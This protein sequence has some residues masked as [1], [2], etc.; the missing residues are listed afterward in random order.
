MD[1]EL[2]LSSAAC[3]S[4]GVLSPFRQQTDYIRKQIAE[5]FDA[6][7]LDR[8]QILIGT[9]YTFQGEER[10]IMLISLA[11]DQEVHPSTFQILDREDVFNVSITRARSEQWIITSL[12][13]PTGY[14]AASQLE[15]YIAHIEQADLQHR[16][17]VKPSYHDTFLTSVVAWLREQGYQEIHRQY[18]IAG[19][20]VDIVLVHQEATFCINLIGYPGEMEEAMSVEQFNILQRVGILALPLSYSR[21]YF[22]TEAAERSLRS[23]LN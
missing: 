21:W 17:K 3:Q 13:Q 23:F 8:H 22:D 5:K 7:L 1:A 15:R 18:T 16:S 2:H 4:I 9:P 6:E 10:D 12:Y 19:I 14:V 11:V 20:E